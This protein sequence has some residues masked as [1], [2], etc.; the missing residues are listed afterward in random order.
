MHR[1]VGF[2]PVG[3]GSPRA[4]HRSNRWGCVLVVNVLCLM[5]LGVSGTLSLGLEML[6]LTVV[7]GGV[8][9][10]AYTRYG[11]AGMYVKKRKGFCKLA[12]EHGCDIIPVY[13]FGKL[14]IG[15]EH[16]APTAYGYAGKELFDFADEEAKSAA[17]NERNSR[18]KKKKKKKA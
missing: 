9:G 1:E 16:S 2:L 6:S 8:M 17:T 3:L 7:P 10:Q 18:K 15:R 13:I 11:E 12:L 4:N 5:G 14:H